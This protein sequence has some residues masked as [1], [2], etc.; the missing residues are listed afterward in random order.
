LVLAEMLRA[1]RRSTVWWTVAVAVTCVALASAYP[2]VRDSSEELDSYMDSLPEGLVELFGAAGG[3]GTPA[4][5]LSSQLYANVL[6]V[7]VIVLGIGAA[8][9][10]VAGS[11]GDRTLEML[12]ANPVG[13]LRVAVERLV[14]VAVITLLVLL[15]ATASLWAVAP[16][17]SLED[18]PG[19]A[20]WA[21]GL[22]VWALVLCF[23]GVTHGVGALTGRRGTAI[24]A[25]SALAGA[26]YVLYGVAGLVPALHWTRWL[27]PWFWFLGSDPLDQG[28]STRLVLQAV[29]L[30]AAVGVVAVAGGLLRLRVR[31]LG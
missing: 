25:G 20:L 29:V 27:S 15:V 31:D 6:P 16:L 8:A 1:R 4:G 18:L 10:S 24:A 13:R 7:I 23:A 9:W 22:A 26:T 28:F 2:S 21:A 11:E 17:L 19:D 12:L 14:G 30:P 5:Y 3:I